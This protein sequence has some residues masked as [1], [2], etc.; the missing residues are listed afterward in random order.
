MSL[1]NEGIEKDDEKIL[2]SDRRWKKI[3]RIL[4]TSAFLND[5][6][7]VDLMDCELIE[8]CI[9]STE[10]QIDKARQIVKKCIEQNG[11]DY[12]S[13]IEEINERIDEF[14][15]HINKSCYKLELN[16][17][18]PITKIIDKKISYQI[19]ID[20]T[21]HWI[22]EDGIYD[23]KSLDKERYVYSFYFDNEKAAVRWK[24]SNS[25]YDIYI[26]SSVYCHQHYV[27]DESVFNKP[28]N[29]GF[30]QRKIKAL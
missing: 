7:E 10:Y 29:Q 19:K 28:E 5:R 26:S 4:K 13:A 11:L 21:L 17:D 8:H 24:N 6:T 16:K 18:N 27:K 12:D 1:Y 3:V 14:S 25:N 30:Y 15:E 22:N 2:V 23:F 9:W 20:N